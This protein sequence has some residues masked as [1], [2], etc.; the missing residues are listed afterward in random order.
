MGAFRGQT[1]ARI[2]AL[3]RDLKP[4]RSSAQDVA[5]SLELGVESTAAILLR[6][7]RYGQVDRVPRETGERIAT[8]AAGATRPKV[9][10]VYTTTP[11]GEARLERLMARGIFGHPGSGGRTL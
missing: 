5:E 10:Y 3:L 4:E 8:N 6:L 7:S 1:T 2:L 9:V 11:K